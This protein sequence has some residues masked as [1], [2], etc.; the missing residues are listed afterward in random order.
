[1]ALYPDLN[2]MLLYSGVVVS[3]HSGVVSP[4]ILKCFSHIDLFVTSFTV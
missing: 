4:L 2:S 3:F 1:M